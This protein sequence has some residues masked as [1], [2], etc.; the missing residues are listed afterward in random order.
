MRKAT[1]LIVNCKVH[2]NYWASTFIPRLGTIRKPP[3]PIALKITL[4]CVLIPVR[5]KRI[6]S[7]MLVHWNLLARRVLYFF[8]SSWFSMRPLSAS[9]TLDGGS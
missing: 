2:K 1:P 4:N 8:S 7:M 3:Q 6:E 5:S 9:L